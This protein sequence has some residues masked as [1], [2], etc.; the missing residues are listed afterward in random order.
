MAKR[1]MV[2]LEDHVWTPSMAK[3][4]HAKAFIVLSYSGRYSLDVWV[5]KTLRKGALSERK[6]WSVWQQVNEALSYLTHDS[7]KDKFVHRDLTMSNIVVDDAASEPVVTLIDFGSMLRL[8]EANPPRRE[9]CPTT[10]TYAPPECDWG[11][12]PSDGEQ[13]VVGEVLSPWWSFDS[14]CA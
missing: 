1:L 8:G 4:P 11:I 3:D 5:E 9:W 12:D 13:D 2:C 7:H 6:L 14:Y 10:Y